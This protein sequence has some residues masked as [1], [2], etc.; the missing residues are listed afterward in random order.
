MRYKTA[1]PILMMGPLGP[2]GLVGKAACGWSDFACGVNTAKQNLGFV[3]KVTASE[4]AWIR[5]SSGPINSS[6]SPTWQVSWACVVGVPDPA[7]RT[8]QS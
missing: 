3:K 1:R 6:S 2:S 5:E 7:K 8:S 4:I